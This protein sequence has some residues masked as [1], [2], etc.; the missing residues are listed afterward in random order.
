MDL[1]RGGETV[2]ASRRSPITAVLRAR[3]ETAVCRRFARCRELEV[4]LAWN[5]GPSLSRGK[6][7]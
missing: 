3:D 1:I 5:D 7:L 6:A 4:L 2:E